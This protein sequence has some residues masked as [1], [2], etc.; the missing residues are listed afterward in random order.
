MAG[1]GPISGN[2]WTFLRVQRDKGISC[3]IHEMT[4]GLNLR[5]SL[6]PG[7]P[8]EG[9]LEVSVLHPDLLGGGE[10]ARDGFHPQ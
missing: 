5:R 7:E 8:S 3:Y 10:M 2:P 6:V 4:L 9:G 1:L